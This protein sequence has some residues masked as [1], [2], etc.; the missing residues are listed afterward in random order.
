MRR[1]PGTRTPAGRRALRAPPAPRTGRPSGCT[2][3]RRTA[4]G[5]WPCPG[6]RSSRRPRPSSPRGGRRVRHRSPCRR[7]A[8][9]EH[10]SAVGA[11]GSF[12]PG[13]RCAGRTWRYRETETRGGGDGARTGGVRVV[14]RE[15]GTGGAGG[16]GGH[17][18][19][20]L[21]DVALLEV[22]AAP[23][24]LP[25]ELELLVV[26]APTQAF[27]MSRPRTREDA[28]RTAGTEA[29]GPTIGVREW[30]R[31]LEPPERPVHAA[32]FDTRIHTPHV[33]VPPRSGHGGYCG[34]TASRSR[35]RPRASGSWGSAARCATVSSTAHGPGASS[36]VSLLPGQHPVV[37]SAH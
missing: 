29:A 16:L 32:T 11:S 24:R 19:S 6:R 4:R 13:C 28:L 30:L 26:G 25:P 7:A 23:R 31:E 14:V 3:R 22:A 18:S 21:P 20:A 15:H 5:R 36:L 37:A 12:G 1:C 2:R 8:C 35:P 27:G 34:A 17:A 33:L 9:S 10:R